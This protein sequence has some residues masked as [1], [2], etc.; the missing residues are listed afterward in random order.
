MERIRN[1]L[2]FPIEGDLNL[3]K[4]ESITPE[5]NE[6]INDGCRR[7]VLNLKNCE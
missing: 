2:I 5:I 3:N 7:I 1:I 6:L 4:V